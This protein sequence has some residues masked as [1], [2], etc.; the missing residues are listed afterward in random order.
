MIE[1]ESIDNARTWHGMCIY[2]GVENPKIP[3]CPNPKSPGV[4]TR[5]API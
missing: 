3:K 1:A 2:G 5:F 4:E